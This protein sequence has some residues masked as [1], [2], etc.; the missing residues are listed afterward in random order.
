MAQHYFCFKPNPNF[1]FKLIVL[2]AAAYLHCLCFHGTASRAFIIFLSALCLQF[3]FFIFS[4][5]FISVRTNTIIHIIASVAPVGCWYMCLIWPVSGSWFTCCSRG[6]YGP[7]SSNPVLV[8]GVFQSL[9]KCQSPPHLN[10]VCLFCGVCLVELWLKFDRASHCQ[11]FKKLGGLYLACNWLLSFADWGLAK[12]QTRYN[13][14]PRATF[15]Q[16]TGFLFQWLD[17]PPS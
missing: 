10:S 17:H 14:Q 1:C 8:W 3:F 6:L 9:N 15:S 16:E 13:V 7:V 2:L 12:L 5:F 4:V 11:L